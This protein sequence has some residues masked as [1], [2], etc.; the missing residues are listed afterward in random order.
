MDFNPVK[1]PIPPSHNEMISEK[2]RAEEQKAHEHSNLGTLPLADLTTSSTKISH[3]TKK[4][5]VEDAILEQLDQILHIQETEIEKELEKLE[6]D[7][8]NQKLVISALLEAGEWSSWAHE[9]FDITDEAASSGL[10]F[11]ENVLPHEL[12][13]KILSEYKFEKLGRLTTLSTV[14]LRALN[15]GSQGVALICRN[16]ILHQSQELCKQ[17]QAACA[18]PASSE[19]T[20]IPQEID[21]TIETQKKQTL[22]PEE[23]KRMGQMLLKWEASLKEEEKILKEEKLQFKISLASTILYV[24]SV[25]LTCFPKEAVL[26]YTKEAAVG[27][28]WILSALEIIVLGL[29]LRKSTK[30]ANTLNKWADAYLK[31]QEQHQPRFNITENGAQR[32]QFFSSFVPIPLSEEEH[33]KALFEFINQAKNLSQIRSHLKDLN[34]SLEPSLTSKK[35]LLLYLQAN[36]LYRNQLVSAYIK[37]HRTIESLNA[38]IVTSRNLLEKRENIVKKKILLLTPHF[39]SI[40]AQIKELKKGTF[41]RDMQQLLWEQIQDPLCT[42]KE[43]KQQLQNWGLYDSPINEKNQKLIQAL[44]QFEIASQEGMPA[45]EQK[46]NVIRELHQWMDH[47]TAMDEQFQDWFQKQSKES[48][49]QFYVD[50]QETIEHTT[51]NALKQMV[52]QKHEIESRFINFKLTKAHIHFAVAA[53]AL[54]IS[55][56]F[57][58]LG[59]IS[60][61]FGGAGLILLLVSLGTTAVSLGLLG[62][63]YYQ[64][65]HEKPHATTTLTLP[66]Q[67]K[68]MWAKIR[69]SIHA[70]F[71]QAKEKKLLAVAKILHRLHSATESAE[72]Q[73]NAEYQIALTNYKKAKLDFEE[74]QEKIKYWSQKLKRLETHLVEKSWQDFAYQ[75]SLKI[76]DSPAAFDTLRAFKEALQA[77]NLHL[78]S[79]ETKTLLEVQLGVDLDALQDQIRK[80]PESIRNTLQEFFVLDDADLVSFI[81]KRE[82]KK[83]FIQ[84]K[85]S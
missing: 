6:N 65:H 79:D 22:A 52:K 7:Q 64:A 30:E 10:E 50:H 48:L 76:A 45:F 75:A 15:S 13:V 34:I 2:R 82:L 4:A 27:I 68:V 72:R 24:L 74:S 25:P 39:H 46:Q 59:L 5:P 16:K 80:D 18:V 60:I 40:E 28:S 67:T 83:A 51:K 36:L 57:V 44:N 77:C 78:L 3:V 33:E 42:S 19:W 55:I 62:A 38:I 61:P 1:G 81:R 71:N 11:L 14:F 43:I 41:V 73:N 31:W 26:E 8:R 17:L 32:V 35:E 53:I 69:T 20:D 12:L 85:F 37:F 9:S 47:S 29:E 56:T 21:E 70:Y 63:S 54:T 66:F 84:S 58:I 23:L 49:I